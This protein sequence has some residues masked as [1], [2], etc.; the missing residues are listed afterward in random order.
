MAQVQADV[1][2]D[3]GALIGTLHS[4]GIRPTN[5]TGDS[6]Y[7]FDPIDQ[8]IDA[9]AEQGR[10][11]IDDM[12]IGTSWQDVAQ[13]SVPR[14]TMRINRA[15]GSGTIVNNTSASLQLNGYSLESET[16]ALNGTGWN[17]LDEQNVGNWLQNL[18]TANQLVESFFM[19]STTVAPGGQLALGNLFTTGKMEDVTGRYSSPDNLLNLFEVEFVT[20]AGITGDYNNNGVVDAVDYVV[21]RD[22]LNTNNTLPNDSSPGTVTQADYDAW[23]A[24]FG[25]SS[26]GGAAL[27]AGA[28]VPEP[29]TLL[30]LLMGMSVVYCFR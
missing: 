20:A 27:S 22:N 6:L 11:Y 7:P 14:L 17:S 12:A 13:V 19:G 5:P 28:Q 15:S 4:Q 9:P 29:A 21:W 24:N 3:L 1:L 18:A 16:G 30:L 23:R 25:R 2:P 10:S 26:G 8:L